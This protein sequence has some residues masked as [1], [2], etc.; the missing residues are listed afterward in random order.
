MNFRS[1][2]FLQD[3]ESFIRIQQKRVL[4]T[5]AFLLSLV[6][7]APQVLN[8]LNENNSFR[9]SQ[10]VMLVREF[11]RNGIDLQSPIPIFGLNSRIPFEFPIFQSIAAVLGHL[12]N[13][14]PISATR[15]VGLV[16]FE[17]SAL[18]LF[19]LAH[20]VLGLAPAFVALVVFLF[21][22]FT[23][24]WAASA[25]IEFC[26]V[27]FMLLSINS[28][29]KYSE[30][31]HFH[32]RNFQLII[33]TLALLI[34]SLV[35]ITTAIVMSVL[36]LFMLERLVNYDVSS[37]TK[38]SFN[39]KAKILFFP[40]VLILA[41]NLAW[42][43]FADSIKVQNKFTALLTSQKLAKWNYGTLQDRLDVTN[44]FKIVNSYWGPVVGG[45][46]GLFLLTV[47]GL[48]FGNKKF[49]Y[50]VILSLIC[51]PFIFFNLYAVHDYY[52][53]AVFPSI[54]LLIAHGYK[55]IF[56]SSLEIFR[57]KKFFLSA[58]FLATLFL[59]S[60]SSSYGK[61]YLYQKF[62]EPNSYPT[63]ASEINMNSSATENVIYVGC[64]WSPFV[65]YY[66]DRA[67]LMIPPWAPK[68][69]ES[70][71]VG[72]QVLAVCSSEPENALQ[73]LDD[74]RAL[75]Y[76]LIM[77]SANVFRLEKIPEFSK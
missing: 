67:A 11:M 69:S 38:F 14:D 52:S 53:I 13:L 35:K 23:L 42:I 10:T 17:L 76:N 34:A 46:G 56:S 45:I 71:L 36:F 22:P 1:L 32:K 28:L 60:A 40:C 27:F 77:L 65:P 66:V 59:T 64:D 68:L 37:F 9:Q 50:P 12:A 54:V 16:F 31:N 47:I 74:I 49:S 21:S 58:F 33:F 55:V 57:T 39:L 18:M 20:K 26:A 24:M 3:L 51:G 48:F 30:E 7:H 8:G 2:N 15:L 73:T 19:L 6:V 4:L 25:T 63:L 61:D 5:L 41:I 70:D 62:I 72:F 75:G 43:Q 44:S 29:Y